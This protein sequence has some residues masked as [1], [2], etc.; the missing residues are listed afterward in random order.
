M[1]RSIRDSM[2]HVGGTAL[3]IDDQVC[4]FLQAHPAVVLSCGL[5]LA[6]EHDP[7]PTM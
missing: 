6:P 7:W 2:H 3:Q 5:E 1:G 4:G